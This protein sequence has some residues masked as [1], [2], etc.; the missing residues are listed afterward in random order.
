MSKAQKI[1]TIVITVL[2]L[3]A[4]VFAVLE[5]TGKWPNNFTYP[6]LAVGSVFE[7]V[8]NWNKNRKLAILELVCAAFFAANTFVG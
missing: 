5:F 7:G 6:V 1:E 3:I 4:A 8:M 2:A